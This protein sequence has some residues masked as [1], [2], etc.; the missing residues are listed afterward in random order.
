[1]HEVDEIGSLMVGERIE[2]SRV[3]QQ[4]SHFPLI[5]SIGRLT[6][7]LQA[8]LPHARESRQGLKLTMWFAHG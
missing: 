4:V 6:T 8:G 2:E 5:A 7:K 3:S 1:V